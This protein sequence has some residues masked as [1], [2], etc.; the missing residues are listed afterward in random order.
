MKF[1]NFIFG[2]RIKIEHEFFGTM[3][4]RENKKDPRKSYFECKRHFQP[5]GKSIEVLVD[6]DAIGVTNRQID[7]YQSIEA[8]Y[9]TI[10]TAIT[11]LIEQN[12]EG[13]KIYD[14]RK[15]F[16]PVCLEIPQ[17][18]TKPV[19][20]VI[21]FESDHDL[22]HTFSITMSDFDAKEVFIDG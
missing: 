11:P 19:T 1:L 12:T 20:W 17:C 2:K 21:S 22:D 9:P 5:T 6:G 14:F 18:E 8:S 10:C 13:I 3:L 4:F 16:T 15:E 7:F